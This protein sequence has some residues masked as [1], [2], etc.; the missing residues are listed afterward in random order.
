MV[1]LVLPEVVAGLGSEGAVLVLAAEWQA[2]RVTRLVR[3]HLLQA[4]VLVGAPGTLVGGRTG[5]VSGLK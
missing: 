2:L 1:L 4:G 3:H 5:H